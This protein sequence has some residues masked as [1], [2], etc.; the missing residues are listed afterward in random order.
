MSINAHLAELNEKHRSLEKRIAEEMS[1]PAAN[2]HKIAV[3][4][5]EKLKLK[6]EIAKLST[7]TSDTYRH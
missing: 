7:T 5:Q 1:H 6:D 4:K 2:T 3:W